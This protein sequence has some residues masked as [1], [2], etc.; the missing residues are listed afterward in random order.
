[1]ASFGFRVFGKPSP[2]GSKIPGVNSETGKMF[3]RDQGGQGLKDWRKNVAQAAELARPGGDC[4]E[5][6]FG[7][8]VPVKV[9]VLFFIDRPKSAKRPLPSVK[10]DLDKYVRA[11]LDSMKDAKMYKDDGQVVELVAY[12]RYATSA[13][14]A[15]AWIAVTDQL[16]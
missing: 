7:A 13:E 1:M 9:Q 12:K 16:G 3:V 5:P 6:T 8:E 14:P 15:G 10:P 11:V 4:T 2:Q